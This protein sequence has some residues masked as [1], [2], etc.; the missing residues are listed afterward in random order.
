MNIVLFGPPAA[1]KGT[2]SENIA[3]ELNYFKLSTGDLLRNEANKKSSLGIKI[4]SLIDQGSL[5]SDD[6]INDV[7]ENILSNEKYFN[8][9]IFDGYP[10]N[11]N[12]AIGLD[13]MLEKSKKN[14]DIVIELTVVKNDLF[15]RI[16]TRSKETQFAR[17]DDT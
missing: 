10:R 14:I 11:I 3:K 7:I 16:R 8:R 4:K 9:I 2:Q 5:V 1:G 12:Q 15:N 17:A 13:K 6:I